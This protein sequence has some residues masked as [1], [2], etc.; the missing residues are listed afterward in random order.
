MYLKK[1]GKN[2]LSYRWHGLLIAF[3][4]IDLS[5]IFLFHWWKYLAPFSLLLLK[6]VLTPYIRDQ[7]YEVIH[8][9]FCYGTNLSWDIQGLVGNE[10]DSGLKCHS[11]WNF[12]PWSAWDSTS[13]LSYAK[14]EQSGLQLKATNVKLH[15]LVR[16]METELCLLP[17]VELFRSTPKITALHTILTVGH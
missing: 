16:R 9:S 7:E 6:F 12:P 1:K 8:W 2:I 14:V 13:H 10:K 5:F 4:L 3:Y 11:W 15:L 17:W